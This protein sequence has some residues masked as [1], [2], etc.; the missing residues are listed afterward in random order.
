[1]TERPLVLVSCGDPIQV[2][3]QRVGPYT[4]WF[5]RAL[6][7]EALGVVDLRDLHHIAA[8]LWGVTWGPPHPSAQA[9]GDGPGGADD[10]ARHHLEAHEQLVRLARAA[11]FERLEGGAWPAVNLWNAVVRPPPAPGEDQPPKS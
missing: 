8:K 9:S 10:A 1:M 6:P 11:G 2:T 3:R 5:Q 7:E 4:L